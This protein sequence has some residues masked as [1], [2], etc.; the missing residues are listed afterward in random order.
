MAGIDA[1]AVAFP[2]AC[3]RFLSCSFMYS[4]YCGVPRRGGTSAGPLRKKIAGSGREFLVDG[5]AAAQDHTDQ[6][7]REDR[8]EMGDADLHRQDT[9]A[10]GCKE[11]MD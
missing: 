6:H 7:E 4:S 8:G 10:M 3:S 2:G 5:P 11:K 1:A 9:R